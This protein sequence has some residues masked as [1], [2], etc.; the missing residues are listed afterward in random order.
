MSSSV[1]SHPNRGKWPNLVGGGT[2]RD[3]STKTSSSSFSL[4]RSVGSG[5]S[6]EVAQEMEIE[7]FGLDLHSGCNILRHS[8][9]D[10]TGKPSRLVS[11]TIPDALR[12]V[13]TGRIYLRSN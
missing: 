2:A 6:V 9:L 4:G 8:L 13:I 7:A 3:T 12:T 5:T 1:I 11:N 10:A